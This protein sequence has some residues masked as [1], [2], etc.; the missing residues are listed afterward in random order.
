MSDYSFEKCPFLKKYWPLGVFAFWDWWILSV[1][2]IVGSKLT[3][4]DLTQVIYER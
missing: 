3:N 2:Q 4:I 1:Q